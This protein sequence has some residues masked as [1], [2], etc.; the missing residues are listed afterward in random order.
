MLWGQPEDNKPS[1][2]LHV[3]SGLL[4][5]PQLQPKI[6]EVRIRKDNSKL[7][8]KENL[9]LELEWKIKQK[10][11]TPKLINSNDSEM[12]SKSI[13]ISEKEPLR[14]TISMNHN[15]SGRIWLAVKS[16]SIDKPRLVTYRTKP[17]DFWTR[18]T[19]TNINLFLSIASP[20]VKA[21]HPSNKNN[22]TSET[23]I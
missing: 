9:F 5:P 2:L 8:D 21:N 4:D 13:K 19:R 10:W 20:G 17:P 23:P 22:I 15:K 11:N 3:K 1:V 7:V 12:A 14:S 16:N 6:E 18:W